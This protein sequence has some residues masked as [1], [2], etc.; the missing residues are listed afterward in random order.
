MHHWYS[1]QIN[2]LVLICFHHNPKYDTYDEETRTLT[3]YHFYV[4]ND[5]KHDSEFVE[6]YFKLHWQHMVEQRYAPKWHFVWLDGCV[7]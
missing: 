5:R 4:S 1:Y 3:Q 6:H 7:A 2:I